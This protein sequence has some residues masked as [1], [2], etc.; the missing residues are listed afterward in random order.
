MGGIMEF[1]TV[2]PKLTFGID[3]KLGHYMMSVRGWS[4]E[5][6]MTKFNKTFLHIDRDFKFTNILDVYC[7]PELDSRDGPL[8]RFKLN[9]A[10]KQV[11][12]I[13]NSGQS[14]KKGTPRRTPCEKK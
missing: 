8:L 14:F 13:N 7:Q 4:S 1:E 3:R 11:K 12:S 5:F 10:F 2:M 9:R 6:S